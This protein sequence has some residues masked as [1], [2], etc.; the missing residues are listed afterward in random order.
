MSICGINSVFSMPRKMTS[1]QPCPV[2]L[3]VPPGE[4][5]GA[6]RLGLLAGLGGRINNAPQRLVSSQA[7]SFMF[8]RTFLTSFSRSLRALCSSSR[9]FFI[10]LLSCLNSWTSSLSA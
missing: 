6:P 3:K 1:V 7:G 2:A 8:L 4:G 10:F 5:C 9:D